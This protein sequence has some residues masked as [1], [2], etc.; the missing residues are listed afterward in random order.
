MDSRCYFYD[1]SVS[2]I[3]NKQFM[4]TGE[5][6]DR[7]ESE[8]NDGSIMNLFGFRSMQNFCCTTVIDT[9]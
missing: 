3:F 1:F 2:N 9:H 5:L 7:R 4:L 8:E 6:N